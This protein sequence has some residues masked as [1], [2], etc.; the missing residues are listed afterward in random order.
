MENPFDYIAF[1]KC[2]IKTFYIV[3]VGV[4]ADDYR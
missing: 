2:E 4:I 1:V 3:C